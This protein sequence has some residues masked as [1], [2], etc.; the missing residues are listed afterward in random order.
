[1][2]DKKL[3]FITGAASGI[4]WEIGKTFA[5]RGYRV[6]LSDR[7]GEKLDAAAG[8]IRYQGFD[9]SGVVCNVTNETEVMQAVRSVEEQWGAIDIL[10]NNAGLQY[11]APV[12]NFPAEKFE[13]L[14]KVMLIGPFLTIKSCLPAMKKRNWGRII[15]MASIN[16]LVGFPGKAAYNSAKHGVIGL[17][18]VVALETAAHGITVNAVCP[19]YVDTPLV[20]NQLAGLAAHRKLP[21][22][23]VLDE[24]IYPLV[25]QRRLLTAQEVAAFVLYLAGE[26]ARGITGQAL[27]MDG[28]YTAQ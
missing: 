15:N 22:E 1:M 6:V 24:V 8:K 23:K 11:V 18:K 3:V 7:D 9:V 16:G 20:R 14:I 4:G 21:V 10:I 5:T 26:D 28:G 2:A 25:P 12:E 17:S 13:Q 19:G 27:V